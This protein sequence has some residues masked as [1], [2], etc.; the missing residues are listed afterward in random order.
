MANGSQKEKSSNLSVFLPSVC[1]LFDALLCYPIAILTSRVTIRFGSGWI[2]LRFLYIMLIFND[3]DF[4]S[5]PIYSIRS[6]SVFYSPNLRKSIPAFWRIC[7][8]A[9]GPRPR[10][11]CTGTHPSR[12]HQCSRCLAC[13]SIAINALSWKLFF[14]YQNKGRRT[15]NMTDWPTDQPMK[16]PNRP[17]KMDVRVHRGVTL[18][19]TSKANLAWLRKG[20]EAGFNGTPEFPIRL[21]IKLHV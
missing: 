10:P 4:R 5:H 2:I 13:N 14:S 19:I 12:T 8:P 11:A 3:W 16:H 18:L 21:K 20:N 1:H 7:W 6:P 15:K 9:R 17:T